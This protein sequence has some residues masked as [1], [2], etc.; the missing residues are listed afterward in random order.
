ML[1]AGC[2]CNEIPL[3]VNQPGDLDLAITRLNLLNRRTRS[4][5]TLRE[6]AIS[7]FHDLLAADET[8]SPVVFEKLRTAMRKNRLV[9]G[10]RPIG[11]ALR[12]HFL[13]HEQFEKLTQTA[14]RIASALE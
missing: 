3:R 6:E 9:Y 12:P 4:T 8:L 10:E 14:E 2:G 11:V 13:H 5:H 7:H 1:R